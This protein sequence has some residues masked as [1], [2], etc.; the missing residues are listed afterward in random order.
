MAETGQVRRAADALVE[1]VTGTLMS[2]TVL[3]HSTAVG[4]VASSR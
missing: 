3:H 4:T 1:T 2:R